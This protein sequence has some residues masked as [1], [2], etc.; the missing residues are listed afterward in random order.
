MLTD[1]LIEPADD[2][3]TTWAWRERCRA[4]ESAQLGTCRVRDPKRSAMLAAK[5]L[6]P[7]EGARVLSV[8][9]GSLV[10]LCPGG[11]RQIYRA[12]PFDHLAAVDHAGRPLVVRSGLLLRWS[13]GDGWRRLYGVPPE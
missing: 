11:A 2:A 4:T 6:L 3:A 7:V 1:L 9:Q 13:A 12:F 5:T 10:E 8:F